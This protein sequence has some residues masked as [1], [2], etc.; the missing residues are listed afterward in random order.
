MIIGPKV[1]SLHKYAALH[2]FII[3]IRS[4][5]S[6]YG[7]GMGSAI[8][9]IINQKSFLEWKLRF[10]H[11]EDGW[12]DL[13]DNRLKGEVYERLN[14]LFPEMTEEEWKVL[15]D[16]VFRNDSYENIILN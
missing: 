12:S 10:L 8:F 9:K 14:K 4:T 1:L 11:E 16:L 7:V 5:C 3:S 2:S 6:I 13:I 15:A